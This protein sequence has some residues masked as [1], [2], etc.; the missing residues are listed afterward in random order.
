MGTVIHEKTVRD[1]TAFFEMNGT[2]NTQVRNNGDATHQW[3]ENLSKLHNPSHDMQPLRLAQKMVQMEPLKRLTA[4]QVMSEIL[5]FREMPNVFCGACCDLSNDTTR[6]VVNEEVWPEMDAA[7]AASLAQ[8]ED[9]FADEQDMSEWEEPQHTIEN[10]IE[11]WQTEQ[12][13][14]DHSGPHQAEQEQPLQDLAPLSVSRG[15]WQQPDFEQIDDGRTIRDVYPDQD[16]LEARSALGYAQPASARFGAILPS[17]GE[18]AEDELQPLMVEVSKNAAQSPEKATGHQDSAKPVTIDESS[19]ENPICRWPSCEGESSTRRTFDTHE[20][21]GTHYRIAHLVHDFAGS[22][23]LDSGRRDFE[24]NGN[25]TADVDKLAFVL[26]DKKDGVSNN[27]TTSTESA[28]ISQM[29]TKAHVQLPLQI[30]RT[31]PDTATT[32][33]SLNASTTARGLAEKDTSPEATV[34]RWKIPL[35]E[36]NAEPKATPGKQTL[37]FDMLPQGKRPEPVVSAPVSAPEQVDMTYHTIMPEPLEEPLSRQMSNN[38]TES[39]GLSDGTTLPKSSRVP[40]YFLASMNRF[41]RT[42]VDALTPRAR[43]S[44]LVPPPLFV[45]GTLMF[46]SI[47]R[48]RAESYIGAEGIYSELH[49]RRLRTD[50]S[51][52][53]RVSFSLQH[54]AEQMTPA[55]LRAYDVW[56]PAGLSCAAIE[57]DTHS[58]Q[59]SQEFQKIHSVAQCRGEVRGF[60]IFGLSEEALKCLDHMFHENALHSL[61]GSKGSN[62]DYWSGRERT[63]KRKNAQVDIGLKGGGSMT[64]DAVTYMWDGALSRLTSVWK[65][66]KFTKSGR[67]QRLSGIGDQQS[68]WVAEEEKLADA[69]GITF[70]MGGDALCD[71]IIRDDRDELCRLVEEAGEN[72]N[73]PCRTYG[74]AIQA[75]AAEGKLEIVEYLL[76]QDAD[77]NARGGQYMHPLIAATVRGRE[78][79]ARAL[80]KAGADVLADGGQYVSPLYQAVDFTDP[81]L[82]FM[83]LEKGAWLT[84]EYQELLDLAAER[85]NKEITRMLEQYDVRNLHLV[86]S[87]RSRDADS[88]RSDGGE[89]SRALERPRAGDRRSDDRQVEMKAS[90][91]VRKVGMEILILKGQRGKWTGIKGVRVM[92]AAISA[93]VS[94]KLLDQLRPHLQSSYKLLDFLKDATMNPDEFVPPN[95]R[96]VIEDRASDQADGPSDRT[97]RYTEGSSRRES[98]GDR[99][100]RTDDPY[101]VAADGSICISCSGR[102]GRRGTGRPC[103]ECAGSGHRRI[104]T[105]SIPGSTRCRTCKGF[106]RVYSDRDRCRACQ[107]AA[108]H[109]MSDIP[110]YPPP[111]Y[112]SQD[113]LPRRG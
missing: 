44:S 93:G 106:G 45:Y 107:G 90:N 102:G 111:P 64:V 27:M 23:L 104:S 79:V 38:P 72:V 20:D 51:D 3:I 61:Y 101:E 49:Q 74:S 15:N 91:V 88:E 31:V 77:V 59:I 86:K 24:G 16:E 21:L 112:A 26:P 83:L 35:E 29:R 105:G 76:E 7:M 97:R 68:V 108:E 46:P 55:V 34:V 53:A 22:C 84:K 66:N 4:P 103:L 75:A 65:I 113:K 8:K 73:A 56:R 52:W 6:S 87:S 50:A 11:D 5:D 37:R 18:A 60:L 96:Q 25:L 95:P 10:T 69:M 100:G 67:F 58:R 63:F 110:D 62:K 30:P 99:Q 48:A 43:L 33:R 42:E 9:P 13:D 14:E 94:E 47:L 81:E 12:N 78:D 89:R 32:A 40:S 36:A 19:V 28:S 57:R 85:G 70:V 82:T 41:T 71:A 92:R 2:G 17:V 54:A 1:M 39:L 98:R 80:I 109:S